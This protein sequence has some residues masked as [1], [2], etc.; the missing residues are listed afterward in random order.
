MHKKLEKLGLRVI[1]QKSL[2]KRHATYDPEL[3]KK[4]ILP[5]LHEGGYTTATAENL[6]THLPKNIK[7]YLLDDG[8]REDQDLKDR[9][10]WCEQPYFYGN[11]YSAE[12]NSPH[13]KLVKLDLTVSH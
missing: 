1:T 9:A 5:L 8:T 4:K 13:L 2:D 12:K 3:C 7:G 11:R 10:K 6:E